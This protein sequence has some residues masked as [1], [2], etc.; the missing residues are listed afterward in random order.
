MSL[1]I[2]Q[3]LRSSFMVAVAFVISVSGIVLMASPVY[4]AQVTADVTVQC[5]PAQDGSATVYVE[6]VSP[7]QPYRIHMAYDT[8]YTGFSAWITDYAAPADEPVFGPYGDPIG[9]EGDDAESVTVTITTNGADPSV[10]LTFDRNPQCGARP[11]RPPV[12]QSLSANGTRYD[13]TIVV[14]VT[15]AYDPDGDILTWSSFRIT[16]APNHGTAQVTPPTADY[17]GAKALIAYHPDTTF[18]GDEFMTYQAS[19]GRGGVASATA[20]V[21]VRDSTPVT[22][23]A[24]TFVEPTRQ[25]TSGQVVVPTQSG[26]RYQ[27]GSV[28]D[29]SG[30]TIDVPQGES[31]TVN[32]FATQSGTTLVGT[33]SWQHEFTYLLEVANKDVQQ[34]DYIN[35]VRVT[36]SNAFGVWF[37]YGVSDDSGRMLPDG[38]VWIE[39]SSSAFVRTPRRML[40][41]NG[42]GETWSDEGGKT[43]TTQIRP[44]GRIIFRCRGHHRTAVFAFSNK[45]S[46]ARVTFVIDIGR[47]Q[48]GQT[49]RA[50]RSFR[51][52][53]SNQPWIRPGRRVVVKAYAPDHAVFGTHRL[54]RAKVPRTCR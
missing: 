11:N 10:S 24:P 18:V 34:R 9:G 3:R 4:A 53:Y 54:A 32:A 27:V 5:N 8:G 51:D 33:K 28:N 43:R 23:T 38:R 20:T 26:V 1:V 52:L 31:V 14:P 44:R 47:Q 36:N 12:V 22:A 45:A 30:M 19:D 46:T 35:R 6:N 25:H 13:E 2:H 29:A 37:N 41:W 49:L 40:M 16:G 42:D 50:G 48:W 21:T 39:P 17:P 7:Q 15:G